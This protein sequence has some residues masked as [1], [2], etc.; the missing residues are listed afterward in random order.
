[1][2]RIRTQLI[3]LT[4]GTALLPIL[5][6]ILIISILGLERP[7]TEFLAPPILVPGLFLALILAG[8]ALVARSISKSF[9]SLTKSALRIARGDLDTPVDHPGTVDATEVATT[10]DSLRASLKEEEARRSRLLMGLS[11]DLRTP[12][13][14]IQG[15]AESLAGGVAEN[16]ARRQHYL[17]VILR[18]TAELD[19]MVK[20]LLE[21]ARTS[22]DQR[23]A[24]KKVMDAH[25]FFTKLAREFEE[26]VQ[27]AGRTFTYRNTLTGQANI[28]LDE[29]LARRVF[30]N[31]VS[32]A[33]R[34]TN[35]GGSIEFE[36]GNSGKR[37]A[38]SIADN[39]IGIPPEDIEHIFE[40]LSRGSNVGNRRGSGLGLSVVKSV[41]D[42][43]GWSI[44]PAPRPGGG[45]R[46][47]V[48]IP[49]CGME[50]AASG[51]S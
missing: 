2:I 25:L 16:E 27:L 7:E 29:H 20:E 45:T 23:R 10:L 17:S 21:Y 18:K 41:A 49:L 28:L 14:L 40:P 24:T 43:L 48:L 46:F 51:G 12:I 34:Y 11:H 13:S 5:I 8:E 15:Y 3:V 42:G 31:L 22:T 9:R 36:I 32:N 4:L 30:E 6:G 50:N 19:A 39:G 35:P 37:V 33:V 47:S 38:A 1:M 26:D 44:H